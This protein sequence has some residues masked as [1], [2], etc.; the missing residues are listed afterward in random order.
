MIIVGRE[1]E[2]YE[3]GIFRTGIK[4]SSSFIV[5]LLIFTEKKTF[6]LD[7]GNIEHV[8]KIADELY[9]YIPNVFSAYDPFVL[10]YELEKLFDKKREEFLRFYEE[11]K[12]KM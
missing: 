4:G 5:R 9:Q 7:G 1:N 6:Y 10:S 3:P 8:E 2:T 12:R 11:E